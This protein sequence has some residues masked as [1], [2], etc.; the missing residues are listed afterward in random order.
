MMS[1]DNPAELNAALSPEETSLVVTAADSQ[2]VNATTATSTS[3]APWD[4]FQST[5]EFEAWLIEAAIA[6]W[7]HLFGQPDYYS[8]W[9]WP[10]GLVGEAVLFRTAGS[11]MTTNDS[12][13][14]FSSTNLQVAGVDEADLVE[15]DGDYL[16]IISGQQLVIVQAGVGES[17]RVVS[18][19]AL[20][21]R[22]VGMYLS[23]D[24]L[25]IVS[26]SGT[27]F[28]LVKWGGIRFVADFNSHAWHESNP[29]TT[30]VTV[31]DINDRTAPTLVQ[32]TEL[33]GQLVTS[34]VVN[35]QLRL[36][37]S[38]E[39]R[40]PM[41]IVRPLE[42]ETGTT[43]DYR[44]L[45]P[46]KPGIELIPNTIQTFQPL[47]A[48]SD[49]MMTIDYWQPISSG[50]YE[51]QEEY[52]A[53]VREQILELAIPQVR[54]LALDG[55]IISETPLFEAA[56]LDRPESL[57]DR[58]VTTI[59]TFDLASND[60]GPVSQAS[61]VSSAPQ[62]Y[63]TAE[64]VYVFAER[65]MNTSEWDGIYSLKTNV[66]KFDI[67]AETHAVERVAK[68]TI[69]GTLLNQ[70]AADE[71]DGYLRVVTKSN[72]WGSTGQSLFVLEQVER[73]LE[74]VGSLTGIAPTERLY[75]VRFLGERAFFVTF[76]KVDP[77]FSVD[78]SDPHEPKLLGELHIPGYSDY[79]QPIDE[80]HLLAIGRGADEATGLFQELQ[81][82]IFDVADMSN[83]QLLHR[84]SFGGGRSTATP[85]TGDRWSIG[86]GDHHAVSYFPSEQVFA[87]PIFSAD[88]W[89]GGMDDP[90][91][92]VGHGGLQ[93][94]TIDVAAGITPIGLIEHD[95]LIDRSLQ[96]GDHLVAIS[97]GTVSVHE[98][99]D[100]A[101][102]LGRI[103]IAAQ[104]GEQPLNL[105]M[106]EPPAA[107]SLAL[108]STALTP[109]AVDDAIGQLS[110]PSVHSWWLPLA[111]LK[112]SSPPPAAASMKVPASQ[113]IDA[114][115]VQ[116]LAIET[117]T[118][119]NPWEESSADHPV[120]D[121]RLDDELSPTDKVTQV[122][123]QLNSH[124]V[125]SL[126]ALPMRVS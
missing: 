111:A 65:S 103:G 113:H 13:G 45:M 25:A 96:I 56:D 55:R 69:D 36:V 17:L 109:P 90:L 75:S 63:S 34:R 78:L 107:E 6:Q 21:G 101:M 110:G 125:A 82:S 67:D 4:R 70:F 27:E 115:L 38:N 40:L 10:G 92:E 41:P 39:L 93:V 42:V 66:W 121:D 20:E 91:F 73:R 50:T 99:T 80:N 33:D 117:V 64:S 60:A 76:R 106:Y 97:S 81:V 100:P 72:G 9:Y 43:P 94:F 16:Y 112:H 47:V 30:T 48:T 57:F 104:P 15:T 37:L 35:G 24:R 62:V 79:L 23:G 119:Q 84:Y 26:S 98:M 102:E 2:H 32:K 122:R 29:P 12:A 71:H 114:N 52:L 44:R 11:A 1:A 116:L 59:A 120:S 53:R 87:L 68:G 8:G 14:N 19:V 31:L 28:G 51:T 5:E 7:G 89:S 22:P 3:D 58:H 124:P 61:V 77:L 85:A 49:D 123:A 95:T 118:P 86:D 18:R 74:V 46:I 54:S 105:A 88:D 108:L 126:L 83:P